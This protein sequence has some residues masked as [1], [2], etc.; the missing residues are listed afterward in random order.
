ME[1]R[2]Q[3]RLRS[4]LMRSKAMLLTEKIKE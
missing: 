4:N 2:L 3:K 1:V